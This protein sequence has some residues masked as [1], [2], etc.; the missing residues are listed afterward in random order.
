MPKKVPYKTL[1]M[2]LVL[3][4]EEVVFRN[5]VSWS[6]SSVLRFLKMWYGGRTAT[7][8]RFSHITLKLTLGLQNLCSF[9]RFTLFDGEIYPLELILVRSY[10]LIFWALTFLIFVSNGTVSSKISIFSSILSIVTR[11]GF[12]AV[13]MK[14]WGTVSPPWDGICWRTL[15]GFKYPREF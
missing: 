6:Q 3:L 14:F 4:F 9:F 2:S 8:D 5:G 10:L 7:L 13:T 11:S 12:C 1:S 15:E